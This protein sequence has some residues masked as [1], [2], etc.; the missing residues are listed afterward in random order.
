MAPGVESLAG[1]LKLRDYGSFI[2]S[3]KAGEFIAIA[4]VDQ[5]SR[6]AGAAEA[7][8]GR[9]A[10]A[11]V[12]FPILEKGRL[13][14]VLFLNN[15]KPRAWTDEELAF[16]REVAERTR[17]G[18][19]RLSAETVS[20]SAAERLDL[21][22]SAAQI[23][24]WDFNPV[25]GAL[26]WDARCKALFGLS[27]D[28]AI[29]WD[30]F[31]AGLHPDDRART[32]KAVQSALDPDGPGAYDIEYR[33]IGLEDSV[34]RWIIA[35]GQAIFEDRVPVRFIGTVLDISAQ[36]RAE[37]DLRASEAQFRTMALGHAQP[38]LDR[39]ARRHARLAEQPA[40]MR[41]AGAQPGLACWA[42]PG[43][44]IVHPDDINAAAGVMPGAAAWHVGHALSKRNFA[45]S[46]HDGLWRWHI[47]RAL[48]RSAMP[49]GD[50]G[51]LG[52]HQHRH[53][54]PE[55]NRRRT[56]RPGNATLEQRV[57]ERTSQLQQTEEALRQAQKME[58]VGQLTGGIAHDFNNL[59]QGITG[60]LD[61][62]QHRI[63]EGRFNGRCR[64]LPQG[65]SRFGEPGGGADAP[66]A[67]LFAPPDARSASRWTSIA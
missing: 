21:T 65:G 3:L 17:A 10:A 24:T 32:E 26:N 18:M 19:Q 11:F 55:G 50:G 46:R 27:P 23:G 35:T 54:G 60:A 12:N 16:V 39:R 38:C 5:D 1:T 13:V 56:G 14:A 63:A 47:A 51:A 25:T 52:R 59:L 67:G 7:L 36:K 8:K 31:I 48:R 34:E 64:T 2:D 9:S 44:A 4:D 43:S 57:Q 30:V 15:A 40:P 42:M 33:T 41:I 37:T 61:R 29:T 62:V 20:R 28:A 53:P 45:C 66:A 49:A 22:L 58:A 6:T